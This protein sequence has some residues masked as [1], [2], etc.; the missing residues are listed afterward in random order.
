GTGRTAALCGGFAFLLASATV[1]LA[2]WMPTVIL[3]AYVWMPAALLLL[4][5]ALRDARPRPVIGLAIVLTMQML[6]G[7]P[8]VTLFT[9]QLVGLR[10]LWQLATVAASRRVPTLGWIAVALLLPALLAAVY[11][12]PAMDAMRESIRRGPLALDELRLPGLSPSWGN[13]R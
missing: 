3:G 10:L 4:E 9:Y 8:Q 1:T 6:A 7:F 5:R 2:T 11:L 13:F 12:V